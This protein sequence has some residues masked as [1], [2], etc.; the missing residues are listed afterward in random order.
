[1]ELGRWLA[2]RKL[3]TAMM[4]VSDGL[5]TDLRRLCAASGVGALID[6]DKLPV[7][8]DIPADSARQLALHGGDDYE[9]VFTVSAHKANR[10]PTIF[11]KLKLTQIGEITNGRKVRIVDKYGRP[12]ELRPAGWDPFRASS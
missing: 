5:S 1:M 9:L 8:P 4:D 7:L 6:Q 2:E 3:A 12:Q 11:H 10:L